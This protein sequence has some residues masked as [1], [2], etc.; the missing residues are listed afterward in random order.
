MKDSWLIA[1][2]FNYVV[3]VEE[4]TN[5]G[6]SYQKIC[7]S[8][9]HWISKHGLV[10]LGYNGPKFTWIR[11]FSSETFKGARHDCALNNTNWRIRFPQTKVVILLKVNS[12]HYPMLITL[13]RPLIPYHSKQLKF[14]AAWLLHPGFQSMVQDEWNNALPFIESKTL[15]ANR[16]TTWNKEHFGHIEKRKTRVWV[17]LAGIQQAMMNP[18]NIHLVKLE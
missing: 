10:D 13:S 12:N 15:L 14:Q 1:G 3:D 2:D 18:G 9:V 4:T 16:M 17:R 6:Y 11:G 8:F 5:L 7:S